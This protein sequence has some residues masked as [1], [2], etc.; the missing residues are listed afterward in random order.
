MFSTVDYENV[1]LS[2]SIFHETRHTIRPLLQRHF[3]STECC[4]ERHTRST[5]DSRVLASLDD[6]AVVALGRTRLG[7]GDAILCL[8]VDVVSPVISVN[9]VVPQD[10][11]L[12]LGAV[13]VVVGWGGDGN[14]GRAEDDQLRRE[15]GARIAFSGDDS[16]FPR[17]G[18]RNRVNVVM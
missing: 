2:T 4:R 13:H 7:E 14:G 9:S 18:V 17:L 16:R 3:F 10:G 12:S 5:Q 6:R 8:D 11:C 15:T 1:A